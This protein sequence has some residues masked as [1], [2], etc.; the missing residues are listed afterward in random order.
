MRYLVVE[1]PTDS[2]AMR[3]S[4]TAMIARPVRLRTRLRTIT[5]ATMTSRKP[6]R[7]VEIV[8]VPEAPWAPLMMAVPPS[9]SPRSSTVSLPV[10]LNSTCRPRSSTPTIRQV[11]ISLMISPNASVT[12]AR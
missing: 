4:R 10:R 2:A 12:M 3:L 11:T 8:S 6:A 1:M 7:N 9:A 5:R